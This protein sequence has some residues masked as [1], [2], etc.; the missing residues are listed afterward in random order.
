MAYDGQYQD[1]DEK[2]GALLKNVINPPPEEQASQQAQA[3][4]P[5][6]PRM[7]V[8]AGEPPNPVLRTRPAQ[9]L[10]FRRLPLQPPHQAA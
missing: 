7:A 2:M 3:Q 9:P 6:N 10:Q 5:V 4:P 1:D 8:P